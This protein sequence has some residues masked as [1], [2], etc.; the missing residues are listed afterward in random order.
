MTAR[1]VFH[2][3]KETTM[4]IYLEQQI[5]E[6][7]AE[8]QVAVDPVER[9]QIEFELELA[10]AELAVLIAEQEGVIDAEPPF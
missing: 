1:V 8:M 5:E 9:R 7:R 6:L 2:N 3:V 4:T 10:N